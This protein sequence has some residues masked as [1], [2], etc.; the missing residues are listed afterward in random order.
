[1][2]YKDPERAMADAEELCT[3]IATTR[4]LLGLSAYPTVR[5]I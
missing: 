4:R 2:Q 5:R 3:L 1:M